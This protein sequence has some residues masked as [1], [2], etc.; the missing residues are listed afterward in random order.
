PDAQRQRRVVDRQMM[1][2]PSPQPAAG[3]AIMSRVAAQLRRPT[4]VEAVRAGIV[5]RVQV[6]QVVAVC[7]IEIDEFV[8]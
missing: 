6:P 2:Q 4:D 8:R 3:G 1:R 7:G 5:S